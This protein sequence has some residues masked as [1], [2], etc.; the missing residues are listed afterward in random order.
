RGALARIRVGLRNATTGPLRGARVRVTLPAALRA[1]GTR[2]VRLGTVR[3][4]RLGV[5]RVAVRV[6]S[7]TRRGL[8]RLTI[9]TTV[10]GETLT[11]RVSL[12][13]R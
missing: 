2:T 5:A 1:G 12:R 8:Y 4:G 6:G 7:R 9:R 13:V 3:V 11:R 10:G